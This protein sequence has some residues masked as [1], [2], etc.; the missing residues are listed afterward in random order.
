MANSTIRALRSNV[1]IIEKVKQEGQNMPHLANRNHRFSLTH[2]RASEGQRHWTHKHLV[3]NNSWNT[4]LSTTHKHVGSWY[5]SNQ[6]K[7]N[8]QN[9]IVNC[10]KQGRSQWTDCH[11]SCSARRQYFFFSTRQAIN[12]VVITII[13]LNIHAQLIHIHSRQNNTVHTHKNTHK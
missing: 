7:T 8:K 6:S 5:G 10:N 9:M 11:I 4:H 13:I 3:T 2:E 12:I 1:R